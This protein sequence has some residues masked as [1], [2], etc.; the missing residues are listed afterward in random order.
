[1]RPLMSLSYPF[2]QWHM[3]AGEGI[4]GSHCTKIR[5][6]SMK[7]NSSCMT[8]P[9]LDTQH[10]KLWTNYGQPKKAWTNYGPACHTTGTTI[11]QILGGGGAGGFA[12]KNWAQ[13][14]PVGGTPIASQH[15]APHCPHPSVSPGE[16]FATFLT[17]ENFPRNHPPAKSHPLTLETSC[18]TSMTAQRVAATERTCVPPRG[19]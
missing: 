4:K 3:K 2:V 9:S 15:P 10:K 13:L 12:D 6:P 11:L 7:G 19:P 8:T 17:D 16:N 14:P 18:G 1:M 5:F